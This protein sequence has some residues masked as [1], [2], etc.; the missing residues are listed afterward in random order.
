VAGS[1]RV[2]EG[3]DRTPLQPLE[4]PSCIGLLALA[5]VLRFLFL[6]KQPLWADE[7]F[8]VYWSQLDPSFLFGRGAHIETNP[9]AYYLLMHAWMQLFGTSELSVRFPSVL[10]SVATVFVIY[11]LSLMLF[12]RRTALLAG[13]FAAIEPA[14]VYYA[15]EARSYAFLGFAEGLAL[16]SL[17][18]YARGSASRGVQ[19]PWVALFILSGVGAISVHYTSVAFVAACFAAIGGY[20]ITTRPFP[21]REILLWCVTGIVVAVCSIGLL[22]IASGLLS[23]ST[24]FSWVPPTTRWTIRNFFL[25][26]ISASIS[27]SDVA[28]VLLGTP[29]FIIF[30]SALRWFRLNKVQFGLL[31]LVPV[32][33]CLI[34][35]GVSISRPILLPRIGIWLTIP[36]SVLLARAA[37]VQPTVWRRHGVV[38]IASGIFLVALGHYFWSY[39]KEDW[40]SA[41]RMAAFQPNCSGPIISNQAVVG[42]TYYEPVLASRSL[43]WLKTTNGT[44]VDP[45][46]VVVSRVLH[47]DIL[48]VRELKTYVQ[49]HHHAVV[50]L[51]AR[52]HQL[53]DPLG[54]ALLYSELP[55]G[56][57]VSCF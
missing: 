18:A 31:V 2:N 19:W 30:C 55:G 44:D 46:F 9:P 56:L 23:S 34:V 36:L 1:G 12:D 14:A 3:L 51:R 27:P 37:T 6:N 4:V 15:Q 17:A 25:Q 11:A 32:I 35:V 10:F 33:F 7:L 43:I 57:L 21:L 50:V 54:S 52:Y 20:L 45:G 26:Q 40:R 22:V 47:P 24:G 5:F 48:D 41:A 39:Q 49:D 8:T 29:L 42:L 53:L 28:T 38:V 16:C 13:L